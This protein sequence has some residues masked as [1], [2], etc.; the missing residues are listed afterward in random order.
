MLMWLRLLA[1]A[2]QCLFLRRGTGSDSSHNVKGLRP[3]EPRFFVH[4]LA[5]THTTHL[6][7]PSQMC[8][9][10]FKTDFIGVQYPVEFVLDIDFVSRYGYISIG[11]IQARCG[12]DTN[13]QQCRV[14]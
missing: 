6:G 11:A 7:R 4:F 2:A 14:R 3:T 10:C 1:K 9:V 5:R 8:S 12:G 13:S